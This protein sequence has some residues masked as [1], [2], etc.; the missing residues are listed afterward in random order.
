[1]RRLTRVQYENSVRD[2]L[3][4]GVRLPSAL[5]PDE[6]SATFASIGGYAV[7]TSPQGVDLYRRAAF[8][9]A[10]QVMDDPARRQALVG[11]AP[12]AAADPC[13]R[14]F[15][16]AFGRRAWRRPL[17]AAELD[18]YQKVVT[19]VAKLDG[20]DVWQGLE[21]AVAGMLQSVS[22][23]YVTEVGEVDPAAKGQRRLTSYEL[24]SRLSYFLWNTT[25][26]EE[27]LR[28]ADGG[29][30]IGADAVR[31]QA[32]RLVASPRAQ[33]SLQQFFSEQLGA[34]RLP[35]VKK[36]PKLY[37][38]ATAAL[39]EAMG[40]ELRRVV[41]E[42]VFVSRSDIAELFDTRVTFV[43][44]DLARLYGVADPG[45]TAFAK[46]TLPEGG[47][48]GGLLT[49]AAP[50]TL[51]ALAVRTSP[52]LRGVFIRERILCQEIPRPPA[53]VSTELPMAA[54]TEAT[55][56]RQRLERHRSDPSCAGCH[57]FFD[58]IGLSLE[59]FDAIGAY[60]ATDAG[61]ALD[62][63]GTLDGE[64]YDGARALGALLRRDP[65]VADC[66]ARQLYQF[67]VGH[68]LTKGEEPLMAGLQ[69]RFAAGGRRV[70]ELL[71][72]IAGS[73]GFRFVS[74]PL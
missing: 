60:R 66:L 55:T 51:N 50:L 56:M 19:D 71:V 33:T 20:M 17:T 24:A 18:R 58:P 67:A 68:A 25:P 21:G 23:V 1:M 59:H 31:A 72:E 14:A 65:R 40:E 7:T 45:A 5:D 12:A 39:L 52:T 26:D 69:Q 64:P 15:L 63:R 10:A 49:L 48:R 43:N 41:T 35:E 11:C 47:A 32:R 3:G 9:L 54:A 36:D 70:L 27:L 37:P 46:V 73:D 13:V 29:A 57:A 44:R 4:A 16:Q 6:T 74:A 62:V 34:E 28:V 38:Q 42:A 61:H 53:E 2:L 22:F 8:D 30:L